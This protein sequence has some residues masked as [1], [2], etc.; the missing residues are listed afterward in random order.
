MNWKFFVATRTRKITTITIGTLFSLFLLYVLVGFLV[1]AP[2]AKWQLEEQLPP[3]IQRKV[4]IEKV[5]LN[6]L[7]LR[8][9]FDK[10]AIEKKD[11]NGNLFSDPATNL[12]T[13]S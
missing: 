13:Q 1:I 10:I 6:P 3:L 9:V 7:T 11:G 2:V 12:W 4:T 5:R 8:V